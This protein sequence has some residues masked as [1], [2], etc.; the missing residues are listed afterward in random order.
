MERK[1]KLII[2]WSAG[3]M[4]LLLVGFVLWLV[5]RR[6]R[7]GES[8]TMTKAEIYAKLGKEYDLEPALICAIARTESSGNGYLPDGR[9]KILF[10]GAIFWGELKKLGLN[11]NAY[12]PEYSDVLNPVWDKSKY[13]KSG[14][15][16]H[17]RLARAEQLCKKL[18]LDNTA[19]LNSASWGEFQIMGF[20]SDKA[21]F[22]SVQAMVAAFRNPKPDTN[23]RAFL[24]FCA[25]KKNR[26]G[27]KP[28]LPALRAK[29]WRTVAYNYNGAGYEQNNYHTKMAANYEKCKTAA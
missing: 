9:P 18:G 8:K 11:P 24:N 17:D 2:F 5:F 12:L 28:L 26:K 4:L 14:A 7:T 1:E 29:D 6:N 23:V 10:E 16:Q 20:S 22:P 25:N 19:A 15:Y 13:G 21:G 3:A 27:E